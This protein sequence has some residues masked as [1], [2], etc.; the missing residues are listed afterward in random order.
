MVFVCPHEQCRVEVKSSTLIK[1]LCHGSAYKI[2]GTYMSGPS[3]KSLKQFLLAMKDGT[4]TV[5]ES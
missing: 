3:H 2:D 4:I 5:T 1:C